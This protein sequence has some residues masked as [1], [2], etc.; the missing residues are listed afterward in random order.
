MSQSIS[1]P[2]VPIGL[3]ILAKGGKIIKKSTLFVAVSLNVVHFE[4][5]G[6]EV[7]VDN[8]KF[9]H[10]LQQSKKESPQFSSSI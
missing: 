3:S 2:L 5:T 10:D 4:S 8:G 6:K 9:L 7:L 1:K